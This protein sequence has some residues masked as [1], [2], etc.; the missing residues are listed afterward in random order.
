MS[1]AK[2]TEDNIEIINERWFL[3]DE[4]P[5]TANKQIKQIQQEDFEDDWIT[6][7]V[8][9]LSGNVVKKNQYEDE[10]IICPDCGKRFLFS[11]K[12]QKQFAL[13][14]WKKPKRCKE[15]RDRRSVR[16]VMRSFC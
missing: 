6:D 14:G 4:F 7:F 12:M 8:N 11:K 5:K 13:K 15:C 16:S 3:R 2:Y 10:Y 1:W 9:L